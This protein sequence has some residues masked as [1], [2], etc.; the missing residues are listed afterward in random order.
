[1][2]MTCVNPKL[3]DDGLMRGKGGPLTLVTMVDEKELRSY[4]QPSTQGSV[5]SSLM[6]EKVPFRWRSCHWVWRKRRH[7]SGLKFESSGM[8]ILRRMSCLWLPVPLAE[9][10]S[11]SRL[12]T[13]QRWSGTAAVKFS[14]RIW[15]YTMRMEI[16]WK[17]IWRLWNLPM[18]PACSRRW[19]KAM[20]DE[21]VI[22][23]R[24]P[25]DC[26]WERS[27]EKQVSFHSV[28]LRVCWSWPHFLLNEPCLTSTAVSP[29]CLGIR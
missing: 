25:N 22:A 29:R 9:T 6:L 5:S 24:I 12:W 18:P 15:G 14:N 21:Q 20:E 26:I 7:F 10:V 28:T 13:Q 1:M 3:P 2:F 19:W 27:K 16:Q 11:L 17:A 23:K 4:T 8:L